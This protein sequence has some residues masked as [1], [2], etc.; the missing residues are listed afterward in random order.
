M[1]FY[2]NLRKF[3]EEITKLSTLSELKKSLETKGLRLKIHASCALSLVEWEVNEEKISGILLSQVGVT[4]SDKEGKHFI[5]SDLFPV[6]VFHEEKECSFLEK[7]REKLVESVL[8][9]R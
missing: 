2:I 8:A 9:M 4:L 1:S 6:Y 3:Q 7:L 5:T